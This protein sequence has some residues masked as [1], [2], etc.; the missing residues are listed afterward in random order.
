MEVHD[1][2]RLLERWGHGPERRVLSYGC[3]F[4]LRSR[5]RMVRN[6][7]QC[8][9]CAT[10]RSGGRA[11]DRPKSAGQGPGS[12]AYDPGEDRSHPSL[13]CAARARATSLRPGAPFSASGRATLARVR[14]LLA[15]E[16]WTP[17]G[18]GGCRPS[19]LAPL[20]RWR[21]PDARSRGSRGDI[22]LPHR[23][24]RRPSFARLLL[25]SPR[26]RPHD[27]TKPTSSQE[28]APFPPTRSPPA[29]VRVPTVACLRL[30][31][32]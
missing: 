6:R 24:R 9:V 17:F 29:T 21:A 27:S 2:G 32:P 3:F 11:H 14:L 18:Q 20:G 8:T 5:A 28:R 19:D 25:P 12:R 10:P 1:R 30:R 16:P 7:P 26:A 15:I 23:R 13:D 4:W 31:H 22:S